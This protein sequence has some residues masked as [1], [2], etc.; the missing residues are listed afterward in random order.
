MPKD[1]HFNI[2]LINNINISRQFKS[3]VFKNYILKTVFP[4]NCCRLSNGNIILVKDIV[5]IDKYKIVGLKYNSLYQ[6]PC[7]ST[8][9]GI[10]MVQVDSVSPLEIFDL[11]KVDCK[12][13]QIEHNSNI[14]IFPLLHTQ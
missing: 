9:F 4:D 5:L 10:C 3:I 12:C 1:E 13:V 2:P 8:D 11:D 14:V 6:N 7:E